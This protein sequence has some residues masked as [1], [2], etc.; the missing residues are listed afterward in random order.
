M[1]APIQNLTYSLIILGIV[2]AIIFLITMMI[3]IT[4]LISPFG[5]MSD[6]L[7]EIGQGGG[8]LTIHLDESRTDEVGRMAHGYNSFV[9]NLVNILAQVSRTADDLQHS[10]SSIDSKT[11]NMESDA[12]SQTETTEQVATAIDEMGATARDIATNAQSAAEHSRQAEE[13]AEQGTDSV[14]QTLESVNNTTAQLTETTTLVNQLSTDTD[15]IDEILEVIR[16]VSEQTNLLA[17]NAAIE[18]AR[19][20]E[21]GRG[22]AVVADEVRKLASKSNES[23]EEIRGTI[24]RLKQQ[25]QIVVHSINKSVD[26]SNLSL[27]Q[28]NQSGQHLNSIVTNM[29]KVN[30]MNFQIAS[31]TE[32]QSNVIEE[33]IPYVSK[34]AEVS[35]HNF[36]SLDNVSQ[37]SQ[38]VKQMAITLNQLVSNFKLEK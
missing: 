35:R 33:I 28:A 16:A 4:R 21:H 38:H 31:A 1:L 11:S 24:E 26:M 15:A 9:K 25:T 2:S 7:E 18:A 5:R 3:V 23:A 37:D 6:L 10:I 17:L 19:A 8:D 14:N 36:T 22:F 30:D 29:V 20:G 12:T 34:I 27:E 32:E 13:L